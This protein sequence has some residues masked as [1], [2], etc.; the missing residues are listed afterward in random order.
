MPTCKV[1]F[2]PNAEVHFVASGAT[3]MAMEIERPPMKAY[4]S[5]LVFGK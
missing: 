5:A 3:N 1:T 2:V 4:A